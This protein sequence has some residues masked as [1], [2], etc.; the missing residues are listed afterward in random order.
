MPAC[1][2]ADYADD[3]NGESDIALIVLASK[4]KATPIKLAAASAAKKLKDQAAVWA[5]G[6]R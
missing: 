1:T 3:P 2:R 6:Y 5:A 4:S